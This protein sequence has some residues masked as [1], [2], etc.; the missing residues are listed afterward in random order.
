[1]KPIVKMT[2][3]NIER[4]NKKGGTSDRI[5]GIAVVIMILV[6]IL[7]FIILEPNSKKLERTCNEYGMEF[8]YDVG[9]N[10][11]EEDGTRHSIAV[12]NCPSP[13]KRG[14]CDIKFI[15]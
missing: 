12:M 13:I 8:Y 7:S 15:K 3:Q 6:I 11:I 9:T 5:L 2:I 4:M 10:C 14:T 1:M